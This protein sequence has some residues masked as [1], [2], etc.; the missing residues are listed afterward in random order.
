MRKFL[1]C[2][3]LLMSP[4]LAWGQELGK[5]YDDSRTLKLAEEL[6]WQALPKSQ[7]LNPAE[8][9]NPSLAQNFSPLAAQ[10]ALP[11][12]PNNAVWLRFALPATKDSPLWYLRIP[13]LQ[14]ERVT[15]YYQDDQNHWL[16][17]EAGDELPMTRWP[18]MTRNP[19]FELHTRANS[20][21]RYYV[22]LEHRKAITEL[23]QLIAPGDYIDGAMRVGTLA[24]LMIGLFGLLT[25][26]SLV[27]ARLY[28]NRHYAW[29][30]LVVLLLL[31]TQLTLL[32]YANLRLWP[33]SVYLM[34]VM[35]VLVPLWALAA[36]TWFTC[37][38]S[39]AK[40]AMPLVY[41]TSLGL[42]AALL[43]L[44]AAFAVSQIA[45]FRS[46]VAPLAGFV[47][48]WNLSAMVWMAWRSQPW[49][50]FV[51]A[52][53]TPLT[54]AMMARLAYT[55]GWLAHVELTQLLST[56]TGCLG[57]TVV[58]VGMLLRSRESYAALEREQALA[59]TDISTGLTLQRVAMIRL[60]QMLARSKRFGIPCGVVMVHWLG[61]EAQL[62]PM[63]ALQR[64]A[65]MAHFGGRLRRLARDIDTV[66][67]YDNAHFM[68]LIESPVT[69]EALNDLGTK[70]LST[71][72][73]P[74]PQLGGD[75]YDVHVAIALTLGG[76]MSAN[77]VVESL[78]TRMN[79]MDANTPRRMQ[80]ID[81]PLSTRP[82]GEDP[83]STGPLS[84]TDIVAK[85]NAIEA[86]HVLPK[87]A[88]RKPDA[89]QEIRGYAGPSVGTVP[90]P[91]QVSTA[92]PA[93]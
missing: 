89:L 93:V 70:I 92:K 20:A 82:P 17:Q 33:T 46:L 55:V 2:V 65:V 49:L 48:L 52:G 8:F 88:P 26:L 59:H 27:T 36:A 15:L 3:C 80:F 54:L 72:M 18:L 35:P 85:I 9:D 40:S 6:Q 44:S 71:C 61:Y 79:Q 47:L 22:K 4:L 45:P 37:Q 39:Y 25:V 78:L 41:K 91:H 42:V 74:S 28:R 64:G 13:R 1:L 67:R 11:T 50:W 14:V 34:K 68:F 43:A 10:Q 30:A 21:R 60:P 57:M 75:V 53:F 24:G 69:R 84:S 77:E 73:R 32:G 12:G 5:L 66:A 7:V 58:Y 63:M 83:D 19:T 76:T 16:M 56:I 90:K 38:I 86:S 29:L 87:I 62:A 81:S 23:V 31:L 51:V